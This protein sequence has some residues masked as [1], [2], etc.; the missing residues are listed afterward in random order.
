MKGP[1]AGIHAKKP[2]QKFHAIAAQ[3]QVHCR[4][5]RLLGVHLRRLEGGP[6]ENARLARS[7]QLLNDRL[8]CVLDRGLFS[9]EEVT[10]QLRHHYAYRP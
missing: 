9:R 4:G 7:T 3:V 10:R 5:P 6:T 1:G 2:I 8:R